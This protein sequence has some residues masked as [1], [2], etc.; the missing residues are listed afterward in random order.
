[1]KKFIR[2]DTAPSEGQAT[3]VLSTAPSV[4]KIL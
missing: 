4:I 3:K 1:M 2:S